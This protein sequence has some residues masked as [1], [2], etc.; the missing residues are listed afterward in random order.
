MENAKEVIYINH[1][2]GAIAIAISL[3]MQLSLLT[4]TLRLCKA[5]G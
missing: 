4:V 3:S 5:S 2:G 1:S